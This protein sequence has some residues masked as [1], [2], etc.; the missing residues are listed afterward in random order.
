[1]QKTFQKILDTKPWVRRIV[2]ERKNGG[3]ILVTLYDSYIWNDS[4]GRSI[5]AFDTMKEVKEKTNF[6]FVVSVD[7]AK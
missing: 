3:S 6:E 5:H 1:M 2:D 7:I 4:F